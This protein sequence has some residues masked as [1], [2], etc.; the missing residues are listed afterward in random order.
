MIE[1]RTDGGDFA[2]VW[3]NGE[4]VCVL[5]S[6]EDDL[7]TAQN[8]LILVAGKLKIEFLRVRLPT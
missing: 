4:L 1:F 7:T 8:L 3:V 6:D 2:E 5:C